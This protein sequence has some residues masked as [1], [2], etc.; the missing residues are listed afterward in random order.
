LFV[1]VLACDAEKETLV[2]P[3]ASPNWNDECWPA[4][5]AA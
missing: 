5:N 3:F 4:V 2:A 1:P